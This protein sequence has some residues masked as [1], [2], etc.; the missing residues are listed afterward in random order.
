MNKKQIQ[1]MQY[2][3]S[4]GLPDISGHH[5]FEVDSRNSSVD[6]PVTWI[7]ETDFTKK[8]F[9]KLQRGANALEIL[10]TIIAEVTENGE[11]THFQKFVEFI[12]SNLENELL[13]EN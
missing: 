6:E 12:N 10:S 9:N 13:I 2:Y 1:D 3:I 4:Y 8:E 11:T 5:D 7:G